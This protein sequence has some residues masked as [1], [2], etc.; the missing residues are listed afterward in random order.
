MAELAETVSDFDHSGIEIRRY[1]DGRGLIAKSK[2]L[3][4]TER[5][6]IPVSLLDDEG[7]ELSAIDA[8]AP[9]SLRQHL[10]DVRRQ[11]VSTLP[12]LACSDLSDALI[13][14]AE[15]HDLGKADVR[16]QAM[17]LSSDATVAWIQRRKLWAKSRWMPRSRNEYLH[18]R[19]L[20]GLP[21][22]FRHELLSVQLVQ[23]MDG[24]AENGHRDLIL[25][26]IATHHGFARPFPLVVPDDDPPSVDL[27][28]LKLDVRRDSEWRRNTPPHALAAGHADRFWRMIRRHGWWGLAYLET[29]LRLADQQVSA[30]YDQKDSTPNKTPT[31]AALA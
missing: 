4:K 8:D 7:D 2:H 10:G 14:A 1:A 28:S 22:G 31:K 11:I 20:S 17:L 21:K 6:P 5:L 19:K 27:E 29:V 30:S 25:H 9:I 15:F 24:L 13:T 3:I 16:F 18:S 26:L 12:A 23:V